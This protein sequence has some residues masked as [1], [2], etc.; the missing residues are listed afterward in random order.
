MF[1]QVLASIHPYTFEH[2]PGDLHPS[3]PPTRYLP[4]LTLPTTHS[5]PHPQSSLF[6]GNSPSLPPFLPPSIPIPTKAL[7]K[8]PSRGE[9]LFLPQCPL[10]PFPQRANR[11]QSQEVILMPRSRC[12]VGDGGD[13]CGG[14]GA[15]AGAMSSLCHPLYH[16][17]SAGTCG[18][19][20]MT[21]QAR[22]TGTHDVQAPLGLW[23]RKGV[24]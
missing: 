3:V 17:T 12:G 1:A 4:T 22:S 14:E 16:L 15:A 13:T 11:Q 10:L 23:E 19:L 8:K 21:I 2:T 5:Q 24:N 6:P 7:G 9:A 18:V 20:R